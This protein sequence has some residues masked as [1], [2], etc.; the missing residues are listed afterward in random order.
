MKSQIL[1]KPLSVDE[2]T[3]QRILHTTLCC[4][5]LLAP[6]ISHAGTVFK[7]GLW[8]VGTA[9]VCIKKANGPSFR[10]I[11]KRVAKEFSGMTGNGPVLGG[12]KVIDH[13]ENNNGY[14]LHLSCWQQYPE[15][16]RFYIP[17]Q[18]S[19]KFFN[20]DSFEKIEKVAINGSG[21]KMTTFVDRYSFVS[22]KCHPYEHKYYPIILPKGT[23]IIYPHPDK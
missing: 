1:N 15:H 19:V 6:S 4:I 16:K 3:S 12:C 2:I 17:F 14:I 7:T 18:L 11:A 23:T 5:I 9:D 20:D 21:H 13:S 22:N 8:Q 10:I